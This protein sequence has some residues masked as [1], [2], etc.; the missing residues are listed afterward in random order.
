[1]AKEDLEELAKAWGISN[2]EASE[3]LTGV[4]KKTLTPDVLA[5]IR[6]RRV[7]KPQDDE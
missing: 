7:D 1:M 4:I 5:A 6:A 3:K 2:D